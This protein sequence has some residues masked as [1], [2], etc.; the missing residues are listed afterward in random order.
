METV[1]TISGGFVGRST[2]N[3]AQKK[4]LLGHNE[5][6][7]QETKGV[8]WV[9]LFHKERFWGYRRGTWWPNDDFDVNRQ[10]PY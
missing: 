9:E 8:I 6:T 5:C 10:L 3:N 7:T 4:I 2:L 1:E